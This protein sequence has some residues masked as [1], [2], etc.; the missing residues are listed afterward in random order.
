MRLEVLALQC[1]RLHLPPIA[2]TIPT[3]AVVHPSPESGEG[4]GDGGQRGGHA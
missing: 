4:R 3:T 1:V 2:W